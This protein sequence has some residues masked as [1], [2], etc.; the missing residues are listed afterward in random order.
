M[1]LQAVTISDITSS[2]DTFS[3]AGLHLTFVLR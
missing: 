3:T 1:Y 2:Q